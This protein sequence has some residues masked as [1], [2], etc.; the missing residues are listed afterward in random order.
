MTTEATQQDLVAKCETSA[1][2]VVPSAGDGL[3]A[4]I[5]GQLAERACADGVKLA[6]SRSAPN[7]GSL[8]GVGGPGRLASAAQRSRLRGLVV[9]HGDLRCPGRRPVGPRPVLVN[10]AGNG[11]LARM[12]ALSAIDYDAVID[13]GDT[14]NRQ[15]GSDR[16][17]VVRPGVHHAGQDHRP[18]AAALDAKLAVLGGASAPERRHHVVRKITANPARPSDQRD[19]IE[20]AQHAGH[21]GNQEHGIVALARPAHRAGQSH[22]PAP[23]VR[24]H[25][26]RDQAVQQQRPQDIPAH[27]GVIALAGV[28]SRPAWSVPGIMVTASS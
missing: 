5:A 7:A 19:L 22:D 12:A 9:A 1:A 8:A 25:G 23:D 13:G 4:E 21:A 16:L 18:V 26:R 6:A 10:T 17:V 3:L 14:L 28:Q 15:R 20:D 24:V 2:A 11:P 27:L